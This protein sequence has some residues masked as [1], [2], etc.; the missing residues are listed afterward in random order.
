M[1]QTQPFSNHKNC[2]ILDY[3]AK[4]VHSSQKTLKERTLKEIFLVTH[5]AIYFNLFNE[6]VYEIYALK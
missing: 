5:T 4:I 1:E 6:V 3:Y 2:H